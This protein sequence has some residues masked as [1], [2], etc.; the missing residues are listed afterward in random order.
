VQH[1]APIE[2]FPPAELRRMLALMLEAPFL[3]VRAALPRM[4]E[5]GWSAR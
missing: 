1:V 4:Y 5:R 3:L 2:E